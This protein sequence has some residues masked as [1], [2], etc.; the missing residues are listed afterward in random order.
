MSLKT[1][2]L[3]LIAFAAAQAVDAQTPAQ[4]PSSSSKPAALT[5]PKAGLKLVQTTPDGALS[6]A[7]LDEASLFDRME[8]DNTRIKELWLLEVFPVDQTTAAPPWSA[9]WTRHVLDCTHMKDSLVQT[10][11]L[12][13]TGKTLRVSETPGAEGKT[14]Y[15]GT[16]MSEMAKTI[17]NPRFGY[18]GPRLTSLDKALKDGRAKSAPASLGISNLQV[19]D[20]RLVGVTDKGATAWA[21]AK[22][23]ARDKWPRIHLMIRY[24]EDIPK[25]GFGGAMRPFRTRTLTLDFDCAGKTSRIG[26][27][28]RYWTANGGIAG[29]GYVALDMQ[30]FATF[31]EAD[32][33]LKQACTTSPATGEIFSGAPAA[34]QNW[35]QSKLT[36]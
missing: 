16:V 24:R 19:L 12:D 36:P 18:T 35:L 17:C 20:W 31:P 6:S 4:R 30:P 1:I 7:F 28:P 14:M 32:G 21:D 11:F 27:T 34:T 5:P 3:G 26:Q 23:P 2:A 15:A 9:E 33:A 13:M 10:N 22:A 25:D 29:V 8:A